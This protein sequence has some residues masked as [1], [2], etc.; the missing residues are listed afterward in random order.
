VPASADQTLRTSP[1]SAR[2]PGL[3]D[4][5]PPGCNQDALACG[6]GKGT[7]RPTSAGSRSLRVGSVITAMRSPG[8]GC[9]F[10]AKGF[11]SFLLRSVKELPP[12][13]ASPAASAAISPSPM[14]E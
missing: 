10:L 4:G 11:S 12:Q 9:S 3:F 2:C 8:S 14:S 1:P 7:G 5:T 13:P 6:G